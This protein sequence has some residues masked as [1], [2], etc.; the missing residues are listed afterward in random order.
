MQFVKA[1]QTN[2]L[3][4]LLGAGLEGGRNYA[5]GRNMFGAA[6]CFACHR[7]NSEGGA[8]G[9]DLTSVAGKYSPHDLLE[10]I[11]DPSKEISDQYGSTVFTLK[12]GSVISGRIANMEENVAHDGLHQHH[13]TRT[14]SP[15]WTTRKRGED[16][17]EQGQH[18]CHAPACSTCRRSDGRF[19]RPARWTCSARRC[20]RT[21]CL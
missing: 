7:F 2:D 6:T 11:L 5:N 8:I 1:W 20:P 16:R 15:M 9:P 13:G 19:P 18:R 14:T 10:H 17:G 4:G 12:D 3:A 21:R